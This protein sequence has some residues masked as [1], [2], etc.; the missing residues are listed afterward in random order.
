[1]V[2]PF[3]EDDG[4]SSCVENKKVSQPS[5]PEPSSVKDEDISFSDIL[6]QSRQ[7]LVLVSEDMADE[8][9]PD[10]LA[11]QVLRHCG[12][13]MVRQM[14]VGVDTDLELEMIQSICDSFHGLA[15]NEMLTYDHNKKGSRSIKS[16][17][18]DL[19]KDNAGVISSIVWVQEA[20]QPPIKEIMSFLKALRGV[21]GD[22]MDLVVA[23]VG[24]PRVETV[25]TPPC[26]MDLSVWHK[27][28]DALGDP[29]LRIESLEVLS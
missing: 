16:S 27:K 11:R 22:G 23:L 8:L 12:T 10:E 13:T 28:V 6:Q 3:V 25:F 26:A 14:I 2:S 5:K 18:A 21:A 19:H 7:S 15:D 1:M 17:P 24:K 4:V 20:W 9:E 29:R